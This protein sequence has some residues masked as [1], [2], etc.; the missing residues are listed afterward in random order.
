MRGREI[1]DEV[2]EFMGLVIPDK[3]VA[4]GLVGHYKD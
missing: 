3:Q 2:R 1:E 4:L